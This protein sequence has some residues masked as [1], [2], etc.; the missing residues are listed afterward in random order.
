MEIEDVLAYGKHE[1]SYTNA[2]E[3]TRRSQ[4]DLK[5]SQDENSY[6][7]TISKHLT[8]I[9]YENRIHNE[10]Q[11]FVDENIEDLQNAINFWMI[12]YDE[13]IERRDADIVKIKMTW[14]T[15]T[16]RRRNLVEVYEAHKK[17]VIE[18]RAVNEERKR[19]AEILKM[20]TKA[21]IRI[22]AWWRGTMVR[23]KLGPY[24]EKKPKKGGKGGKGGKGKKK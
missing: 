10:I 11:S 16:E 15:L 19:L 6:N 3:I 24:K 22:Q 5:L 12:H 20:Q 18:R 4:H 1:L 17:F 21:A 13:E 7:D 8:K 2:W 14:E 23:N 9:E